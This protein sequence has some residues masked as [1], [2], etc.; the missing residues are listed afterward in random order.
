MPAPGPLLENGL[1]YSAG[2]AEGGLL[3]SEIEPTVI[4]SAASAG[5][6]I[7]S[8]PAGTES[9][10]TPGVHPRSGRVV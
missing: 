3:V 4:P 9:G 6:D 5:G 2:A 1:G 7:L 8:R 10:P